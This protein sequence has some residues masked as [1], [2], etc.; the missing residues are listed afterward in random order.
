MA[1]SRTRIAC[2]LLV[3]LMVRPKVKQRWDALKTW[4]RSPGNILKGMRLEDY[5]ADDL[6]DGGNYH[7]VTDTA[8]YGEMAGKAD[9]GAAAEGADQG[10]DDIS[11]QTRVLVLGSISNTRFDLT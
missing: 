5:T 4:P 8:R 6:A 7:G 3:G 1:H 11:V 2:T 9:Y 10:F